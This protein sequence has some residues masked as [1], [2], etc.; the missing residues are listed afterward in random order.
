MVAQADKNSWAHP[1]HYSQVELPR[2]PAY[3]AMRFGQCSTFSS[4]FS[5]QQSHCMIIERYLK[6]CRHAPTIWRLSLSLT[7]SEHR[8]QEPRILGQIDRKCSLAKEMRKELSNLAFLQR[9][10]IYGQKGSEN[11]AGFLSSRL[12]ERYVLSFLERR[13]SQDRRSS[14]YLNW[15]TL[16]Q[17]CAARTAAIATHSIDFFTE[18][19]REL[20]TSSE[21]GVSNST[22]KEIGSPPLMWVVRTAKRIETGN[23]VN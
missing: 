20:E 12:A 2:L 6:H 21:A 22:K 1:K 19:S 16:F 4:N 9:I 23:K 3:N 18:S 10:H 17:F 13:H 8:L 7:D 14:R 15:L 11:L 5:A